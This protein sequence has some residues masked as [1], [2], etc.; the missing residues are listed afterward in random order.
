MPKFRLIQQTSQNQATSESAGG[1]YSLFQ[2]QKSS[3]CVHFD[4]ADQLEVQLPFVCCLQS[5]M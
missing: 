2:A 4:Q 5:Y 3:N 1:L